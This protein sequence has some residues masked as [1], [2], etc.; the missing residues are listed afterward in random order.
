MTRIVVDDGEDDVRAGPSPICPNF[1]FSGPH[2]L[3]YPPEFG[4]TDAGGARNV[5]AAGVIDLG[6]R[7]V[8]RPYTDIPRSPRFGLQRH[9]MGE[10]GGDPQ[11]RSHDRSGLGMIVV[12]GCERRTARLVCM[13]TDDV[14]GDFVDHRRL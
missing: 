12:I 2:H 11:R 10:I 9:F 1:V 7:R 13:T 6:G 4:A 8:R 14:D 5:D 3:S